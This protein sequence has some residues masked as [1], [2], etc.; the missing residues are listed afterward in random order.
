MDRSHDTLN[1]S[2]QPINWRNFTTCLFIGFGLFV[3]G[4][5]TGIIS[6]TLTKTDFLLYMG[7]IDTDGNATPGSTGLIG[8]TTSIYSVG[9]ILILRYSVVNS[10]DRLVGL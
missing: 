9:S 4:Y 7:L 8:A 6:T 3:Y 10:C 5:F 1:H 2:R